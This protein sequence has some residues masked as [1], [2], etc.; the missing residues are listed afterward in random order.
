MNNDERTIKILSQ[1][2]EDLDLALIKAKAQLEYVEDEDIE[3]WN[4]KNFIFF[5]KD[6]RG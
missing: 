3:T 1:L 5:D 4:A 2:K 6:F